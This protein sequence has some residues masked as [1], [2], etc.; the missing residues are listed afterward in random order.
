MVT[1]S[2]SATARGSGSASSR[3]TLPSGAPAAT[4]APTSWECSSSEFAKDESCMHV[5]SPRDVSKILSSVSICTHFSCAN[6]AEC[7]ELCVNNVPADLAFGG[8]LRGFDYD[9][10]SGEC[11]CVY[12]AGALDSRNSYR[13]DRI[14]GPSGYYPSGRGSVSG[15]IIGRPPSFCG[16]LVGSDAPRYGMM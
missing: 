7:S 15:A 11:G 3:M 5:S 12:D 6:A 16:K 4:A 2:R 9:G 8:R 1:S 10:A 13:F 14:A